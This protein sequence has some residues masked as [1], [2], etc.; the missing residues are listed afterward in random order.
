M[1]SVLIEKRRRVSAM[2]GLVTALIVGVIGV[3]S[4]GA[5][6]GG[7]SIP[8]FNGIM[9]FPPITEVGGPERYVWRVEHGPNQT[10]RAVSATEA[11]VD[12]P[13]G[14]A[15]VTIVATKA[16]DARGTEVPTTLELSEGD[17]VTLVVHHRSG[18]YVYPVTG[19]ERP[20]SNEPT[21]VP[22]P[23]AEKQI[24][25]STPTTVCTVPALHG[26]SLAGAKAHLRAAHCS[27]GEVRLA[28]GATAGKGRVVKQFRNVGAQLAAGAPVALKL[29][30]AR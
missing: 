14:I 17:L 7:S 2:T 1:A 24:E 20:I 3:A 4:A 13:D 23:P 8:T 16:F 6:P 27:I 30:P 29:G 25:D 10:L 21:I 12:Y 18:A 26:L 22:G 5:D 19:G 15:A 9:A 11:E 28:P